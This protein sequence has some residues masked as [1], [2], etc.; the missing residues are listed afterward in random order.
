[1]VLYENLNRQDLVASFINAAPVNV[2][3]SQKL[4]A[5]K[6]LREDL[7]SSHMQGCIG[8]TCQG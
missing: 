6:V 3:E 4:P 1:M 5:G 8:V 2:Q 7:S